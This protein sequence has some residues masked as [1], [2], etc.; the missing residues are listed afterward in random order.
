MV[1]S[2]YVPARYCRLKAVSTPPPDA[3]V[4]VPPAGLPVA[5]R[6]S[7]A[8]ADGPIEADP[9]KTGRIPVRLWW[10]LALVVLFHGGL[11][12]AGTF[13][14][15]YDAYVHI[16][17][18]DH[19]A[20]GWFS[21]WDQRWYTGFTTVSYPPGTHMSIAA[22]SGV[23]GSLETAF[24]IVQLASLLLLTVGVYRFSRLWVDD[25]VAAN[26][27]LL[28]VVSSAIAQT[29]HLYGQLPTTFALA[30]LLNALPSIRKWVFEG[31]YV[32]LFVGTIVLAA[33]TAGH[34]VTTL[35]GSVF[36][37][38]PVLVAG[39]LSQS[40]VARDGEIEAF[41]PAIER[42]TIGPLVARRLRRVWPAV[43]RGGI[44]GPCILAA[45]VVVVLPYWIWSGSDPI[46]QI[47][48]PHGSRANFLADLNIG[49]IFFFIPWGLM[50]PVLPYALI[51][52]VV[53]R[54]WP[55]AASILLLFV[56]GSG[57]T[58]PLPKILLRAAF[59]ILTLDR[60]TFW[61]T[62]QILPL[63]GL[64]VKSLEDGSIAG[65]FRR[66]GGPVLLRTA[67]VG[68]IG[69][70]LALCLFSA[71][72]ARFRP[73]QP[74]S[75]DPD[76]IVAFMEKDQHE[77][78]RFLTL[79]FGDQM[80]WLSAQ[81]TATQVDG[82]YH[83]V[84]RLPELTSTSVERL[85]GAK[86]RGISGL[87]SLQQF[88][89]V[90]EKYHLK[91]V[92]S[93][94]AFYDPLLHFLGW[95]ELGPLENGIVVWEK[96]DIA[97]LPSVLPTREVP[98]WQ[99]FMWGT[100]P[101]TMIVSALILLTWSAIGRPGLRTPVRPP[102]TAI[103]IGP[104]AWI[105]RRLQRR[106]SLLSPA[107]GRRTASAGTER[108]GVVVLGR[109]RRRLHRRVGPRRRLGRMV[110]LTAVIG[111]LPISGL[112]GGSTSADPT[113]VVESY[114]DH[115][116]FRRWEAAYD[117]LDPIT[118]P[119][120]ELWRLQI[121]VEGGL[122]A[123][124]AKL[125]S[126]TARRLN[127]GA[128]HNGIPT[129]ADVDDV[130]RNRQGDRSTVRVDV[131]YLTALDWYSVQRDHEIVERD[132][133]WFLVAD[134]PDLTVPPDQLVR[135]PTVDYLI[136]GRRRVTSLTSELT[137]IQDRPELAIDGAKLVERRGL[138]VVVGEVANVDVDPADI[139]LTAVLRNDDEEIVARYNATDHLMRT[140]NPGESSPFRI[141]F[142]EV[143]AGTN[144]DFNPLDFSPI[145]LDDE[146][147]SVELYAKA[148]VT[149]KGL[150]RGV[151]L[152]S[153]DLIELDDGSHVLRGE[154]RNDGVVEA[155]IPMALISFLDESG[156]VGWVERVYLDTAIRS[157]R[158]SDF[159]YELPSLDDIDPVDIDISVFANGS[160]RQ[161][162]TSDRSTGDIAAP[163]DS[164]FASIGID[165]V[166]M[167]PPG[168][169][170]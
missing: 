56:L 35:F 3:A 111:L 103:L 97:P 51:R 99:R 128:P 164:P 158:A 73:F 121:S 43:I 69:S 1:Q 90:P 42:Q 116:D 170:G 5:S 117:L 127:D 67:Q 75:I 93:N 71:S 80:A 32:D 30:F 14:G 168:T 61:A 26:A 150:Y 89:E 40:R 88:L 102:H 140:L 52:A 19:Y 23:T 144:L 92:F 11:L 65:W 112:V 8:P 38:G 157:Q 62:I 72:L 154:V 33:C 4:S 60:F 104:A 131:R 143:A 101:P 107:G 57:G 151:Q 55:L 125:D 27:S 152:N 98:S 54:M 83:S 100:V 126:F 114:Y 162:V 129:D 86:Y 133:S 159:R 136:Q 58:T 115:L 106:A 85:E 96:G 109:V 82:N 48:I 15:T 20:R 16:F 95:Q 41:D 66:T 142:E 77:R 160:D 110:A 64:F 120:Y 59:D 123:S 46:T 134:E 137:D 18:G 130:G 76:P 2:I 53:D 161:R 7:A 47:P 25:D 94:D 91:Y 31:R 70:M 68:F 166:T 124:Y 45:L 36:F 163:T 145:E 34:H 132:G 139:T 17:L 29:V 37:L 141:E 149:Q 28:L 122:V 39:L 79:G 165:L 113:D 118:R 12:L 119:N 169:P 146:I 74:D 81:T 105:D 138:P 22:L 135:R 50:L 87:G 147:V 108:W 84:R 155:V 9:T 21:T 49:L 153:L 78:W 24:V 6:S 156:E 167:V 148:V 13:R 63:A 10:A 44:L